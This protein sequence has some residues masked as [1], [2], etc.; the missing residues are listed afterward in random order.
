MVSN[1][2]CNIKGIWQAE[3]FFKTYIRKDI[4]L[5][6]N[7]VEKQQGQDKIDSLAKLTN[8]QLL[9]EEIKTIK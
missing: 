2:V 3:R 6:K 8:K 4:A 1:H 9:D 5:I 7:A